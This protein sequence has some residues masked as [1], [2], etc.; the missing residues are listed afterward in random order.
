[1]ISFSCICFDIFTL[2]DLKTR[3]KLCKKKKR[4]DNLHQEL[5]VSDLVDGSA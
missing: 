2:N 5:E 3:V 4:S 1:M